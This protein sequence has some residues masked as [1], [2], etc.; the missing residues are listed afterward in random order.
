[1]S[2]YPQPLFVSPALPTELLWHIIH[3][4]I[5]P[6]TLLICSSR[7]E[8]LSS[9]ATDLKQQNQNPHPKPPDDENQDHTRQGPGISTTSQLLAA[10]LYQVAVARHI[11][12]LFIPTVSHLRAFLS[13]FSVDTA[14][15]SAPP[16]PPPLQQPHTADSSSTTGPPP[17]LLVYGFLDL[18]RDTSEW[19]VQGLSNTTA[20]LIE[21]ARRVAFQAV[22][23]EPKTEVTTEQQLLAE[24]MPVLSGSA[25]R[26]GPD[27]ESGGW[28]GRTVDVRR[29]LGRWF[30]FRQRDWK[31]EA[32]RSIS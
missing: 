31:R 11:R 21:A 17:L 28:T 32:D 20:V 10:P 2:A 25:R 7:A 18:H 3:H 13:V 27:F 4:C 24:R 12:V 30:R 14:K 8:F 15:V 16:Q 29:V 6:T 19:S 9:A 26:V 5:Y 22:V 1:M 23:V